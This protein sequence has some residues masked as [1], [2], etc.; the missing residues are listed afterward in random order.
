MA[1]PE[2]KI[3]LSK[4]HR[5]LTRSILNNDIGEF[6]KVLKE[7]SSLNV[8]F[9]SSGKMTPL[10]TAASQGRKEMCEKLLSMKANVEAKNSLGFTPLISAATNGHEGVVATL[11][12]AGADKNVTSIKG[13]TAASLATQK[14][15]NNVVGILS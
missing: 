8:S 9:V 6:D 12:K 10:H 5:S 7:N 11:L 1:T 2:E 15:F 3:K 13:D 4:I 14:G